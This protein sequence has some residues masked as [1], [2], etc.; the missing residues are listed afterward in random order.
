MFRIET[1]SVVTK[2]RPDGWYNIKVCVRIEDK[3][4]ILWYHNPSVKKE[5]LAD[6]YASATLQAV[7]KYK[8]D[9]NGKFS[10]DSF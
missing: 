3:E 7:A 4:Y 1:S 8:D 2:P 10:R 6:I 9:L 5:Y